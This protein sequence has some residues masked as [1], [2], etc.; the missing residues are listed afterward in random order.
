MS[1][2]LMSRVAGD[3]MAALARGTR[4]QKTKSSNEDL[5]REAGHLRQLC[6]EVSRTMTGVMRHDQLGEV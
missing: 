5:E 3:L 2:G 1:V 4:L 6:E